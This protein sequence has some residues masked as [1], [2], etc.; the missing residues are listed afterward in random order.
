[1][2]VTVHISSYASGNYA[3]CEHFPSLTAAK[4]YFRSAVN[5]GFAPMYLD[6][7]GVEGKPDATMAVYPYTPEDN[8]MMAHNDY[9]LALFSVG[10]R[11]YDEYTIRREN[12]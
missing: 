8:D 7:I 5:G 1:M 3:F 12:I 11:R 10:Q 4:D 2:R 6:G 9:P